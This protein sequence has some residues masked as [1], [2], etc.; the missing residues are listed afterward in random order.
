MSHIVRQRSL[1]PTLLILLG[2]GLLAW[3]VFVLLGGSSEFLSGDLAE[4]A[5]RTIST[6]LLH[7]AMLAFGAIALALVGY[8]HFKQNYPQ[9]G[10]TSGAIA[11]VLAFSLFYPTISPDSTAGAKDGSNNAATELTAS[12]IVEEGLVS[13][14]VFSE[15]RPAAVVG[16]QV[17]YEGDVKNGVTV[18]KITK[19]QVQFEKNGRLWTQE[20]QSAPPKHWR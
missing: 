11:A 6:N 5:A 12:E 19:E 4:R 2:W 17:L 18:V 15:D 10:L 8:L 9:A 7:S 1:L 13:G 3:N 14:I 16:T 20:V